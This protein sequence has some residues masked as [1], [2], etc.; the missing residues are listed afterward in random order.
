MTKV[1]YFSNVTE[2]TSRFVKKLG[3]PALRI[4]LRATDEPVFADERFVLI[5]PTYGGG[6]DTKAVPKQVVKFLNH[7][8]NAQ[9][10]IGVV[11][12]GNTNFGADYCLA[13]NRIA[14]RFFVPVIHRFEIFGTPDDVEIVHNRLELLK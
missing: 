9:L 3:M 8:P 2:N 1:I 4:P 5:C 12:S 7:K 6:A 10:L 14:A 13:A 11:G